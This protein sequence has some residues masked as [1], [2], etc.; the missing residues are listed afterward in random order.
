MGEDFV[1][2]KAM[3]TLGREHN[4][5]AFFMQMVKPVPRKPL[6]IWQ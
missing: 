1:E 5:T 6:P 3:R 4:E 2:L